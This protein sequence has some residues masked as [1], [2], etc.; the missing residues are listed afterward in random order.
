[1]C[2]ELY[3]V[4]CVLVRH[5]RCSSGMNPCRGSRYGH[6]PPPVQLHHRRFQVGLCGVCARRVRERS[7][8]PCRNAPG[9]GALVPRSE[10]FALSPLQ[11]L[12]LLLQRQMTL[13][14]RDPVVVRARLMQSVVF[15]FIIGGLWFQLGT[16][17]DDTRCGTPLHLYPD[18]GRQADTFLHALRW[19]PP[20]AHSPVPSPP[21]AQ[22]N[23]ARIIARGS[24]LS[25]CDSIAASGFCVS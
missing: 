11:Q 21:P 6:S 10:A 1:M 23:A 7:W 25:L 4:C 5:H 18:V 13:F 2:C 17:I 9:E 19:G 20:Q 24:H 16:D 3:A 22:H 12:Q 15:S 14:L 8:W